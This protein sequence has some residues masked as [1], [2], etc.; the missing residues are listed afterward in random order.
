MH[1]LYTSQCG[2]TTETEH[3]K[4]YGIFKREKRSVL[5]IYDRHSEMQS[6]WDKV[7]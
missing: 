2:N 1:R 3:G 7:L 6:K 4:F 5:M